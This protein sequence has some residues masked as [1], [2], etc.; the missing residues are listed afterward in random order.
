MR[1][2]LIM[3]I[4]RGW[5]RFAPNRKNPPPQEAAWGADSAKETGNRDGDDF[6]S[7]DD[8]PFII[9]TSCRLGFNG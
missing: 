7:A 5:R 4:R 3:L 2:D 6:P 8:F 1:D 9:P